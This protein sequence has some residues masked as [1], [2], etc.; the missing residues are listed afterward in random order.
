MARAPTPPRPLLCPQTARPGRSSRRLHRSPR[1]R[2]PAALRPTEN[3]PAF[4]TAPCRPATQHPLGRPTPPRPAPLRPAPP[5][6]VP[7][8]QQG[9]AATA[10]AAR[11]VSRAIIGSSGALAVTPPPTTTTPPPPHHPHGTSRVAHGPA[12][13]ACMFAKSSPARFRNAPT[14]MPSEP[15]PTAT[16]G[17]LIAL[18]SSRPPLPPQQRPARNCWHWLGAVALATATC[19]CPSARPPLSAAGPRCVFHCAQRPGPGAGGGE[20]RPYTQRTV[21]AALFICV[22]SPVRCATCIL[23]AALRL[24][25]LPHPACL[26][27]LP[28]VML[29]PGALHT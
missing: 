8:G 3:V 16:R 27:A 28:P 29:T 9:V 21:R 6:R 13:P 18:T 22:L 14:L 23:I 12:P 4:L 19:A 11:R 7:A 15:R 2:P 20:P 24:R 1:P 17:C 26:L 25:A 10:A 5:A